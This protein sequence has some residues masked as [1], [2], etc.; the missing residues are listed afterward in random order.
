MPRPLFVGA[1]T[2]NT[3]LLSKARKTILL[4]RRLRIS[5]RWHLA[6]Q[7]EMGRRKDKR[8]LL[9]A[10]MQNRGIGQSIVLSRL[11]ILLCPNLQFV[12]CDL[13]LGHSCYMEPPRFS[14]LSVSTPLR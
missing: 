7:N 3:L 11:S 8:S 14:L 9:A 1:G 2:S 5:G 4:P 6:S 12:Y 13:I 10:R